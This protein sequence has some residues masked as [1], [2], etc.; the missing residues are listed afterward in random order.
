ME[1]ERELITTDATTA[2]RD[3]APSSQ[4]GMQD[5]AL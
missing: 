5:I 1:A 4:I 3:T 2:A